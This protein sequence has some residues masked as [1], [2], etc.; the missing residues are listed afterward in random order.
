M[1]LGAPRYRKR[2]SW[3]SPEKIAHVSSYVLPKSNETG[4]EVWTNIPYPADD[5]KNG[6]GLY[7]RCDWT[8]CAS[9][10]HRTILCP[11]LLSRVNDSPVPKNASSCRIAND[12][13]TCRR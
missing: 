1:S 6:I 2:S 12:A 5:R 8:P 7:I 3:S 11:R 4:V 9:W 13:Q 10:A